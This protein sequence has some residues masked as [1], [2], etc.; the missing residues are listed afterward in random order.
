MIDID[1]FAPWPLL[2]IIFKNNWSWT[3]LMTFFLKNSYAS[4]ESKETVRPQT[5]TLEDKI[6]PHT[7]SGRGRI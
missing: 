7:D 6:G 3:Y 2:Q 1:S 5:Q 4:L